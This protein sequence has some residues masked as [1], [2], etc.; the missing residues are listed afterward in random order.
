MGVPVLL[1]YLGFIGDSGIANVGPPLRDHE[2]WQ[3]VIR[4][5][6]GGVLP[7]RFFDHWLPC[8]KAQM[9]MVVR[10][11]KVL[12]QSPSTATGNIRP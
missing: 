11:M 12:E 5:Y 7:E 4:A 8:G 1:V 6:T 3:S 9:R 10:S 2:H